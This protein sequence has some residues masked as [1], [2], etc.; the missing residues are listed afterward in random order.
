MLELFE[1]QRN[2]ICESTTHLRSRKISLPLAETFVRVH[3]QD[4]GSLMEA[5][6]GSRQREVI[7]RVGKWHLQKWKLSCSKRKDLRPNLAVYFWSMENPDIWMGGTCLIRHN[8]LNPPSKRRVW[9]SE[10]KQATH[11]E[12][13]NRCLAVMS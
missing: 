9:P 12:G 11:S 3:N 6:L 7:F 13:R 2:C 4:Q 5:S 1:N 8:L 10:K